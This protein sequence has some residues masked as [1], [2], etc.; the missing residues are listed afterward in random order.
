MT[1]LTNYVFYATKE[2]EGGIA[3]RLH[4]TILF[5]ISLFF[6]DVQ[7]SFAAVDST[8]LTPPTTT[9]RKLCYNVTVDGVTISGNDQYFTSS[10]AG[11]CTRVGTGNSLNY[12]GS[13]APQSI[14]GF[15]NASASCPST[16]PYL[17]KYNKT[18]DYS[19]WFW[20]ILPFFHG[21]ERTDNV[22]CCKTPL[23]VTSMTSSWETPDASGKCASG[24]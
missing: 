23:H 12:G 21:S 7:A 15:G 11:A 5:L 18:Y 2:I 20:F 8:T 4:L 17:K 13:P 22:V 16:H 19:F 9:K 10:A 6:I 24:I 3:M 1:R 14:S